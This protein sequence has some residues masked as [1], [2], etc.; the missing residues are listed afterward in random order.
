M[1][2]I[3]IENID[4]FIKVLYLNN[5][6]TKNSMTYEMGLEFNQTI[7]DLQNDPQLRVLIIT[8]K[9]GVFSSGGD[10]N[11]LKS[12]KNKSFEEN[13]KFM[14]HFYSLFLEVRKTPFAVIAA[15]N[16]HAIGAALAFALSCDL[17]YFVYE[18]KYSFNFLKIG[19]HP[20]MGSTFLIKEMA[21]LQVAQELLFTGKTI[22]GEEAYIKGLCNGVFHKEEI[23]SKVIEIAKEIAENAPIPFRMLKKNLYEVKNLEEALELESISQSKSFLT[24]D[25]QEAILAIEEKRKPFYKNE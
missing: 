10:L 3:Q 19:I 2:F 7:K 8:G 17:K 14:K 11:L 22:N 15:V 4:S 21:S 1:S 5:P 16:G 25:F 20:G 6:S 13:Q 23:L 18:G 9:N 12:F 24:K